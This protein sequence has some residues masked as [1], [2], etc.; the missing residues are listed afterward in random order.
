M[1]ILRS[2]AQAKGLDMAVVFENIAESHEAYQRNFVIDGKK[3]PMIKS[4]CSRIMQIVL[5]LQSN[6]LKFTSEG[7]VKII[8]RIIEDRTSLSDENAIEIEVEDTG[9]GISEQDQC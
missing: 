6:A 2:K 4:D 9:L 1:S 3:S 8:V 7:H 5:G